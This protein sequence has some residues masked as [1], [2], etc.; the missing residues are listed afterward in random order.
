M[1]GAVARRAGRGQA[2][3][4]LAR[5]VRQVDFVICL[6]TTLP[7]PDTAVRRGV[8]LARTLARSPLARRAAR[9]ASRRCRI[10]QVFYGDFCNEHRFIV[11]TVCRSKTDFVDKTYERDYD[12]FY[13][14]ETRKV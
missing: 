6:Y 3:P 13:W 11:A 12:Q 1:D 4:T 8:V 9:A 14:N 2:S 5:S 10:A 7:V